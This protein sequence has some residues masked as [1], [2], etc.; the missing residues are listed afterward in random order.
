MSKY[1]VAATAPI[2]ATGIQTKD[3]RPVVAL[4]TLTYEKYPDEV[5]V[6]A[7]ALQP[8]G[9]VLPV[10]GSAPDDRIDWETIP[11]ANAAAEG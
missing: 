4:M 9:A 7:G 2:A 8:N 10:L 5:Y 11:R 6:C 3:G 1:R